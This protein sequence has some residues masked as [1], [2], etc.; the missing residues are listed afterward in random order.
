MQQEDQAKTQADATVVEQAIE[1]VAQELMST[2]E[3]EIVVEQP[4]VSTESY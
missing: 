1:E 4:Q 2:Q 3:P